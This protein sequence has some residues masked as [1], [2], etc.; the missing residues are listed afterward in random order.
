[1]GADKVRAVEREYEKVN[2]QLKDSKKQLNAVESQVGTFSEKVKAKFAGVK[3]SVKSAFSSENIKTALGGI[4]V[5]AGAFLGSSLNEAKDAEKIN[6]DLEQT[7][8]STKG[9]AGMTAESLEDL[10]RSM[11]ENTAY[12]ED[13]VKSGESMLLTFTQIGKDVFPQ[14]TAAT[15]DYA[16]KM[17]VDA[18]S[19]ALTLGKALNDPA[20][21]LSKLTK[22]GVTFT[23][24]QKKQITAMQKA[25]D[26][27]GAQKLMIA[28]LNKEFGGQAAAAA[29][30]YAGKQKQLENTLKEVKETIGGALM[31]VLA[32]IMKTIAPIIQKIAEFVTQ[33]PKLTAAILAIVAVIGTLVGGLSLV[34][35]VMSA[36][37][38]AQTVALGPLALV[39][40][41]IAGLAA[42]AVVVVTHWKPISAF[43]KNLWSGIL[44]FFKKLP[45]EFSSVA[46]SIGDKIVHGFDS[47]VSFIKSLPT[48][49]LQWGK[50][51]IAGLANGI[52][53]AIG[54]VEDAVSTVAQK[55]RSFLHFSKP[56]EGPLAD[57][58][59]YGK[60]F[61]ALLAQTIKDHSGE[62][63]EAAKLAAKQVSDR[64]AS[65]KANLAST[66][67]QLTAQL[68][69]LSSAETKALSGTTGKQRSA[70]EAEYAKKKKIIQSEIAL[71][72]QQADAEIAQINK[73][74]QAVESALTAEGEKNKS[75]VEGV[76]SLEKEVEDALKNKYTAEE[77][78]AENALNKELDALE[79]W[80]TAQE[81]AINSVYTARE[82]AIQAQI[83]ALDKETAAEDRTATRK[84]Y[85]D[86]ITDLQGQ[87]TYSH[88]DYNKSQLQKQLAAEQADY[89]TELDK[90]ARD[91]RKAALQ[92]QLDAVKN[93]QSSELQSV[94]DTY[95]AKKKALDDQLQTTKD[96]YAKMETDAALEAKAEQLIMVTDQ[97][98]NTAVCG[99][100]A[101]TVQQLDTTTLFTQYQTWLNE[102]IAAHASD[103][104]GWES[105]MA[106]DLA[107]FQ[108]NF[109][110]W[111]NTVKGTL[112]ADTAGHLLDLVNQKPDKVTPSAAGNLAALNSGGT[113]ADSGKQTSDFAASSHASAHATGGSDPLTPAQIGAATATTLTATVPVSWTASGSYYYQ[114]V[115]VAGMLATDNPIADILP[116]SDNDA[117]KLYAEA[118]GKVQS[119]D[120]LD[121]AVKLW[122]TA[123]PTTAFPVVFKVVR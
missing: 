31:P 33:H 118:W 10:S 123:A 93:E 88:D 47:A 98:L 45:G 87:I 84:G 105:Q 80:K 11:V 51:F 122:C 111:F 57:A 83:D 58:D 8:K 5:A 94:D 60:D 116:G 26:I 37:A 38:A 89:Q 109:T 9:A 14:A 54:T 28:E 72:K 104:T 90:E 106:A 97:R 3:E 67:A 20:T 82:N 62:P 76:N 44:E 107:T 42:L 117:N 86:K 7:L 92:S 103:N 39:V 66:T 96:T 113:L 49:A 35:T 12:S 120:T 43:F 91:D 21:G 48:K 59:Q 119:I 100:V 68:N 2:S 52:K 4:G 53:G 70:I 36:F 101:A 99:V 22:S 1:M 79:T 95:D 34:T 78:D 75:F 81:D 16:Q 69:S 63:A 102:Q 73:V 74:K 19:A 13:E 64:L 61:M 85:T 55:I 65:V 108:A 56:D 30:T 25:G 110:T 18:K 114:Q 6:T 112:D 121:G 50:D 29:D 115:S 46:K 15:L 23:D 27:A 71:R 77:Q 24:A 40:A 17:G 41:A 32:S